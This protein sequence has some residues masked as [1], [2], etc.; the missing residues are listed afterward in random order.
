MHDPLHWQG[1]SADVPATGA[2][3]EVPAAFTAWARDVLGTETPFLDY[4]PAVLRR[5]Q[6]NPLSTPDCLAVTAR[7]STAAQW[8]TPLRANPWDA[9]L[10]HALA[11][12]WFWWAVHDLGERSRW[13]LLAGAQGL[14]PDPTAPR[15]ELAAAAGC[16]DPAPATP[17]Y[18]QLWENFA[19]FAAM[20][21][22]N[23]GFW[24]A[25][26]GLSRQE[27]LRH[28]DHLA[29]QVCHWLETL[30]PSAVRHTFG[31]TIAAMDILAAEGARARALFTDERLLALDMVALDWR[32]GTAVVTSGKAGLQHLGLIDEVRRL[33]DRQ[34]LTIPESKPLAR[35]RW[36]LSPYYVVLHLFDSGLHSA[37]LQAI[38]ELPAAVR[39]SPDVRHLEAQCQCCLAVQALAAGDETT[40]LRRAAAAL[41]LCDE[42]ATR[43]PI[44]R[45][46]SS[47]CIKC[48]EKAAARSQDAGIACLENAIR[49]TALRPL[50][51]LLG[52]WLAKRAVE[53]LQAAE[54]QMLRSTAG[55]DDQLQAMRQAIADLERG[56]ALGAGETQFRPACDH[57][58]QLLQEA[59]WGF[60]GLS[61]RW[62]RQLVAAY[63]AAR[64]GEWDKAVDILRRVLE[65]ERAHRSNTILRH[66]LAEYLY[67]RAEHHASVC[68][69]VLRLDGHTAAAGR[70]TPIP[71]AEMGT[72]LQRALADLAEAVTLDAGLTLK[73]QTLESRLREW[74]RG[75]ALRQTLSL[76]YQPPASLSREDHRIGK[77]IHLWFQIILTLSLIGVPLVILLRGMS[78]WALILVPLF[79]AAAV[80]WRKH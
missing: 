65:G 52:T 26:D 75:G 3:E 73:A 18:R 16:Q 46:L 80:T 61:R 45:D 32:R 39:H 9:D 43:R 51:P 31:R 79:I 17:E 69:S 12:L 28:R 27:S 47:I 7:A 58:R 33:A 49:L 64:Q 40:G 78:V 29:R 19:V 72:L 55:G 50:E 54:R 41:A 24:Q 37:A 13:L 63:S 30:P 76:R 11:V 44:E 10:A 48:A 36:A 60:L 70:A 4:S 35:L 68:A 23:P 2:A 38:E 56:L 15:A 59:E 66:K 62:Q 57:A 74:Q 67:R 8:E 14:T 22:A 20:A 6:P 53:R 21:L 34:L 71:E 5:L 77:A 42:D 1:S 25:A